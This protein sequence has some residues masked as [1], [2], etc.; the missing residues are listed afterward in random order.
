VTDR[1]SRLKR[2]A[3]RSLV[4]GPV[5]TVVGAAL[6]GGGLWLGLD[7]TGGLMLG[8]GALLALIGV[9]LVVL[10]GWCVVVLIEGSLRGRSNRPVAHDRK[11]GE[12]RCHSGPARISPSGRR[13]LRMTHIPVA[14]AL[15][16]L[17]LSAAGGSDGPASRASPQP[18]LPAAGMRPGDCGPADGGLP[19]A[20]S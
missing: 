15:V 12:A 6:G 8:L 3:R 4:A 10:G 18:S 16:T 7:L 14:L 13:V 1:G 2:T 5:L 19:L 20:I 17:P 9:S 11:P